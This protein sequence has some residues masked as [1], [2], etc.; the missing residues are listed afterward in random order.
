MSRVNADVAKHFRPGVQVGQEI[1][2]SVPR[3][4][5]QKVCEVLPQFNDAGTM[6]WDT[7]KGNPFDSVEKTFV[8]PVVGKN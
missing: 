4:C 7:K 6:V 2:V 8:L 5:P 1:R 3:E